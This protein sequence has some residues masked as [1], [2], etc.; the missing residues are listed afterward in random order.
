MP[1]KSYQARIL[2]DGFD[3]SNTSNTLKVDTDAQALEYNTFQE[4][5]ALSIPGVPKASIE[6]GGYYN[7][8]AAGTLEAELY[9]R[10]GTGAVVVVAV[11]LDTAGAVPVAYVIPSSY[12][13]QLTIN[14]PVKELLT[15]MGKWPTANGRMYR[16]YQVARATISA[17]GAVTGIDFGA[18]GIAGG[19]AWLF[20]QAITGTATNATIKVQSDSAADFGS[21]ADE[22]T[23]TFSAVGAYEIDL[24][25]TVGRY[26]R[27]NC[28]SKGGATSFL[29]LA[30]VALS[31]V[32]Y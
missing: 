15:V 14:A 23:F 4:P 31:G 22:G 6:H 7:G 21:A 3:F 13:Q 8:K 1:V 12:N 18:G 32:T 17:T 24:A 2:V 25:G 10:L 5:A 28:T 29:V 26:V 19:K 30:V 11:I 9:T 27:L 16:G 20:V